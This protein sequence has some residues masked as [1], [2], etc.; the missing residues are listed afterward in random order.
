MSYAVIGH[1]AVLGLAEEV[2][3]GT[4]VVPPTHW[5]PLVSGGLDV[6]HDVRPVPVLFTGNGN[7]H[8]TRDAVNLAHDPGGDIVTIPCYDSTA[9]LLLLKHALGAV[10]T[11]GAGP[12]THT[13]QP[14][15]QGVV[16]LTGHLRHGAHASLDR[17]ET[18]DGLKVSDWEFSAEARDYARF[19]ATVIGRRSGGLVA[20]SG[21]PTYPTAE[22]VSGHHVGALVLGATSHVLTRFSVRGSHRL[23]RRP[24]L[25]QTHTSEP[26]PSDFAEVT[27][28]GRCEWESNQ[29]YADFLAS[30]SQTGTV[31]I[32]GTGNNRIIVNL[33]NTIITKCSKPVD[34]AGVLA[35]E[36]EGR[37]RADAT[38]RGVSFEVRNDN[39]AAI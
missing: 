3:Y 10:A 28:S 20:T 32:T 31:T 17:A 2:T 15:T 27:F 6:E 30:T 23:S 37:A 7:Y 9:F 19:R 18:F 1:T 21:T 12:Y 33:H 8:N 22:E 25:G 24:A 26:Q 29:L 16:G 34:K 35:F 11:T 5:L 13:F 38:N 4:A 39:S 14:L 36:F